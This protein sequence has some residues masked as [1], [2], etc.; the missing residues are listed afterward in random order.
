MGRALLVVAALAALLLYTV[1]GLRIAQHKSR[2][3][4]A[5]AAFKVP[6]SS[7]TTATQTTSAAGTVPSLI[8]LNPFHFPQMLNLALS[9]FKGKY[10]S[11]K[12]ERELRQEFTRLFLPKV[13][14]PWLMGSRAMGLELPGGELVAAVD[15]SLQPRSLKALDQTTIIRRRLLYKPQELHPYLCNLVVSREHRRKGYARRLVGEC[16]AQGRR[17]GHGMLYLHV[18]EKEKAALALYTALGFYKVGFESYAT[19]MRCSTDR[20]ADGEGGKAEERLT[21][22]RW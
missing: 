7:S 13:I 21:S 11:E 20:G 18:E 16:L 14:F 5:A 2:L 4:I 22:S 12:E 8:T 10:M 6:S 15:V 9:E 1:S 17:W 3:H 19:L